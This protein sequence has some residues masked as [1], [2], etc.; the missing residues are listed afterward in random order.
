MTFRSGKSKKLPEIAETKTRNSQ[1]IRAG[2]YE[3]EAEDEVEVVSYAT[4]CE[5]VAA[6][7]EMHDRR[8]EEQWLRKKGLKDEEEV[9]YA[10]TKYIG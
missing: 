1:P 3:D 5:T 7:L 6:K 8:A 10:G 9:N 4:V 2:E